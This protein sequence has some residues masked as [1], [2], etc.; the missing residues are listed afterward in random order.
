MTPQVR[1]NDLAWYEKVTDFVNGPSMSAGMFSVSFVELGNYPQAAFTFNLSFANAQPPFDVW[2]ETPNGGVANFLTGAGGYL[3][4]LAFGYPG[5][6]INDNAM[7]LNPYMLENGNIVTIRGMN[8]L[9]NRLTI[10][11]TTQSIS[12]TLQSIM[13]NEEEF[14]QVYNKNTTDTVGYHSYVPS[15]ASTSSTICDEEWKQTISETYSSDDLHN[16]LYPTART[17]LFERNQIGRVRLASGYILKIQ[18]LVL[19]DNNGNTYP[20]VAD[21]TVTLPLQRISIMG[22]SNMGK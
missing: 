15:C 20:L 21:N 22:A 8:Y 6:R 10:S 16:L 7:S 1:A 5:L 18:P 17:T 3:Q 11:Y 12:V 14:N 4:T 19:I 9:G 2:R 13:N